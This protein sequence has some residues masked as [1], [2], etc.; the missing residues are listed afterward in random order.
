MPLSTYLNLRLGELAHTKLTVELA[1]RI[2]KYPKGIAENVL[3][4]PFKLKRIQGDDLMPTIED[5]EITEEFRTRDDEL[6]TGIDDSLDLNLHTLTSSYYYFAVLDDMD[7]HRDQGMGNVIF[8]EPFLREV[9]I[10]ARQF[11][12]MIT[13]YEVTYQMVR[14][15]PRFKHHTNE[16]CNKIPPLLKVKDKDKK[17]GISHPY[18][19]L[20]GF[21]K[22]VLNLGPDYIQDKKTE[23]W[24]T[25]EHISV[26]EME[27]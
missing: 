12:G 4:E 27:W 1:D 23:E 7:A 18:Q 24:L 17:N 20:K 8:G 26:H 21:Y 2:V 15:R 14:S 11:E 10:K 13:I 22:G 6:D 25:Y 3:A 19:K 5:G 9:R 16:Q